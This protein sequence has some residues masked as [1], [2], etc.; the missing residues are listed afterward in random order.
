MGRQALDA[1]RGQYFMLDPDKLVLIVDK[2]HP[3]Y[4]RRV[5]K[6]LTEQFIRNIDAFGVKKPIDGR[7]NGADVEV[8]EGRRRTRGAREVNRRRRA[9]GREPL[10]VPVILHR[11]SDADMD[12]LMVIGNECRED[13]D[14][15]TRAEKASRLIE[16]IGLEKTALA[17]GRSPD[18]V[19]GWLKL[20]DLSEEVRERVRSGDL[21]AAAAL[22][23]AE[24][25]REEQAATLAPLART[26]SADVKAAVL[27][28][29]DPERQKKKERFFAARKSLLEVAGTYAEGES[30]LEE[31]KEA[32]KAYGR[33]LTKA[34]GGRKL[35]KAEAATR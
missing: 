12:V 29:T 2:A 32:A 26:G 15:V 7:K 35:E 13:D 14:L 8:A 4:D 28:K 10:L 23:L 30:T 31:L 27:S 16:Q 25:S 3:L 34:K 1:P 19:E 17:F 20:L 5:E 18:T 22:P 9:E 24:L 11:C 33:S 21:S 6:P